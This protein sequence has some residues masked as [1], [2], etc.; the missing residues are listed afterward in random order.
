M[1]GEQ[2]IRAATVKQNEGYSYGGW[3][4]I[5]I[6]MV[7]SAMPIGK[8]RSLPVSLYYSRNNREYYRE[9]NWQNTMKTCL[10][11]RIILI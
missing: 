9:E 6:D 8:V 3:P 4:S 2:V 11:L 7:L 1:P 5:L 10:V